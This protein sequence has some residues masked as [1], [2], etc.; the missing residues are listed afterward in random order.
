MNRQ[1]T[2]S[3][4]IDMSQMT[5]PAA[6][7]AK[8]LLAWFQLTTKL[9]S[10]NNSPKA[11]LCRFALLILP[12]LLCA[13]C[14][15]GPNFTRP[16]APKVTAYTADKTNPKTVS[17]GRELPGQW[18]D[19]YRS[20]PL[21]AL[22]ARA[23]KNNP[24]LQSAGAALNQAQ[25]LAKAKNSELLP[26]V[27]AS[28]SASQQQFSG[29]LFGNSGSGAN[30]SLFNASVP[31][32]YKLDMFGA[33]RREIEGLN[34]EAEY[35]K[36][37][38]EGVFL[39]LAGNI[40]TTAI[41]EASL[42]AQIAATETI[43]ASQNQQLAILER[44]V[45][46]GGV[47]QS[48]LLSQQ[49]ALAQS[50]ATLPALQKA[51]ALARH[52]LAVLVGD[53]PSNEPAAQFTLAELHLPETLPLSIPSKLVEQRPDIR[54]QAAAWHNASAQIGVVAAN[55]FPDFTLNANIGTLANRA[56]GLLVPGSEVWSVGANLLQPVFHGGDFK[57]KRTAAVASYQQ[58]AANYQSTVLT[59][60]QQVAD[61]L[62]ALEFDTA[63]L[64]S[65]DAAEQA[66]RENLS[67]AHQQV[68][69]GAESP[70]ATL[71][72]E[73]NYQQTRL[74]QIKAQAA[75]LADTA[76]LF[77]A[78]GGGWWKRGSLSAAIKAEQNLK[79]TP[80]NGFDCWLNPLPT[81]RR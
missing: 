59:A 67:L 79:E 19:V 18:W 68:R 52:R 23:I 58:A 36:F 38:L 73:S 61:T 2:I 14:T 51:V 31:I 7:P 34:A 46:L 6:R 9:P 47:A 5:Q 50:R 29:S 43:I 77:Q 11:K 32:S 22:I 53:F 12:T 44:Q 45:Q 71:A 62:S 10:F 41:E 13:S 26:T 81:P 66:A 54:A 60:F 70:L 16:V 63:T 64:K 39:T 57:S 20:K 40:V 27:D 17:L 35:Q 74:G 21:S 15:L 28:L 55:V 65:Q 75:R 3:K 69:L 76:A 78:L 25:A 30:F 56:G 80:C 37:Q 8:Q 42:R 24:D 49:T 4:T 1:S 48:A 72:L 33:V